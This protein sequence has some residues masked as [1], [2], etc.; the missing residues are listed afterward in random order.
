MYAQQCV[1]LPF[2]FSSEIFQSMMPKLY[3]T[4]W[5]ARLLIVSEASSPGFSS[6]DQ[7]YSP[8]IFFVEVLFHF[9]CYAIALIYMFLV[10]LL[11]ACVFIYVSMFP[12]ET[13]LFSYEL[14]EARFSRPNSILMSSLNV[15]FFYFFMLCYFICHA[16]KYN[17]YKL[18]LN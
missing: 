9:P 3:S 5:T 4:T 18:C 1:F 8:I 12:V 14:A 15:Y 16:I 17:K 13:S 11:F 7:S 6:K 10:Q 2:F